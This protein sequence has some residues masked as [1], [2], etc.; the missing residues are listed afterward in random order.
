MSFKDGKFGLLTIVGKINDDVFICDCKC[1]NQIKIWRSLLAC[2]VQRDCGMC[3]RIRNGRY[4]LGSV[5][6]HVRLYRTK[7]GR[8]R[9]YATTEYNSWSNM[10]SRC[11]NKNHHAW[12]DYGGRGIRVCERW[13]EP[14]GWGF[15]NF[16]RDMGPRPVGKTLDRINPQNHYEPG[17][18]RWATPKDQGNNQRRWRWQDCAPP[19]VEKIRVME[20]R[21]AEEYGLETL[22]GGMAY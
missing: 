14:G 11:A 16:I 20:A 1:G 4:Y 12:E 22:D 21:V 6:G 15:F 18:C 9:R 17:N 2:N 8:V 13:R 19:P 5:H 7:D 10:V 3:S